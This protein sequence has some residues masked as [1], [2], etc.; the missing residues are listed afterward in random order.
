M[1]KIEKF[2][3]TYYY[4]KQGYVEKKTHITVVVLCNYKIILRH[5]LAPFFEREKMLC[6]S[7]IRKYNQSGLTMTPA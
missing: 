2:P 7:N 4:I 6:F 1:V 3:T 5:I